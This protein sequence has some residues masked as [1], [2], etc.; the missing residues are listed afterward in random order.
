MK[1]E[2]AISNMAVPRAIMLLIAVQAQPFGIKMQ[3]AIGLRVNCK[4]YTA[5]R[6]ER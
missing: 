4:R 1:E 2:I 5:E 3:L 6:E